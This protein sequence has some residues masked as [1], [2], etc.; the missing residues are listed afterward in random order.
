MGD[1]LLLPLSLPGRALTF[2]M[3]ATITIFGFIYPISSM[4][5]F[6]LCVF[7]VSSTSRIGP[8]LEVLLGSLFTEKKQQEDWQAHDPLSVPACL[9]SVGLQQSISQLAPQL[10]L[11]RKW[12][13][14]RLRCLKLYV[15]NNLNNLLVG[16]IYFLY[17]F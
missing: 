4:P 13:K 3:Q 5:R 17:C 12:V 1:L 7:S 9:P 11:S 14:C 2:G 10:W 6:I 15:A 16:F 8:F